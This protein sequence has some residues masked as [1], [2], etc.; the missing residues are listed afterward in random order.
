MVQLLLQIL[1]EGSFPKWAFPRWANKP[2]QNMVELWTNPKKAPKRAKGG[3]HFFSDTGKAHSLLNNKIRYV[4]SWRLL[5]LNCL[6]VGEMNTWLYKKYF[7]GYLN[8]QNIFF[9][10][11][12]CWRIATSYCVDWIK[13]S[14]LLNVLLWNFHESI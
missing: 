14:V 8:N 12:L 4:L 3:F 1:Q 11:K 9:F 2:R 13:W 7:L 10:A 5:M 6:E